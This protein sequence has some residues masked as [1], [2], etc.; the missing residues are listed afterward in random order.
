[1]RNNS[2]L[3]SLFNVSNGTTCKELWNKEFRIIQDIACLYLR[4]MKLKHGVKRWEM[5]ST[6]DF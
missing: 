2:N 3:N 1:M 6:E 5:F 4:N